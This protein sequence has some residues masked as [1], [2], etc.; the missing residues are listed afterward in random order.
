MRKPHQVAVM[1][2]CI[3]Q[4][5]IMTMLDRSHSALE[6]TDF[7][8]F[9]GIGF[10]ACT[11]IDD[12]M[13][14]QLEAAPG[15][16]PPSAP[17]LD[18]MTKR[19]LTVIQINGGEPLTGLHK[20]NGDMHRDRAFSRTSLLV[21]NNDHVWHTGRF[22]CGIQHGRASPVL[23]RGVAPLRAMVIRRKAVAGVYRPVDHVQE[24]VEADGR[25]PERR[26]IGPHNTGRSRWRT[27]TSGAT[28]MAGQKNGTA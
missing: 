10:V 4:Y 7:N 11:A 9:V 22:R 28:C 23:E 21:S 20:R 24:A 15:A 25:T 14:R 27:R 12:E 18:V 3:D 8:R 13:R 6:I 16:T 2:G 19:P 1:R 17:V 26:Q 5:K